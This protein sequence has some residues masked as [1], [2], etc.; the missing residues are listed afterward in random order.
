ML[1]SSSVAVLKMSH[2]VPSLP[3]VPPTAAQWML[4]PLLDAQAL[5][6]VPDA[7]E[8]RAS[9]PKGKPR[10]SNLHVEVSEDT[11]CGQVGRTIYPGLS[12]SC[13]SCPVCEMGPGQ[14]WCRGEI[15]LTH[16]LPSPRIGVGSRG[17]R[18]LPHPCGEPDA[19]SR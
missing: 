6:E 9:V 2:P 13:L 18:G 16:C 14:R 1:S 10:Q 15:R 12:P 8:I 19:G 4:V 3:C 7:I 11:I 5:L 17:E